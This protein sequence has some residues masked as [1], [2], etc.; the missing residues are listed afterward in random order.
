LQ[1]VLTAAL[2]RHTIGCDAAKVRLGNM[3]VSII[4]CRCAAG[5]L[6]ES[7]DKY[8]NRIDAPLAK[9]DSRQ[10]LRA[11]TKVINLIIMQ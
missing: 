7:R 5:T 8:A 1:H 10:A 3:T 9:A 6:Q 4:G 2:D 11:G